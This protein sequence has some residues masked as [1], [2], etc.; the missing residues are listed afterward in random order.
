MSRKIFYDFEVFSDD[1]MVVL[2]DYDTR[3]E[4]VIVNDVNEVLVFL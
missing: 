1:W 4:K 3:A 2:I